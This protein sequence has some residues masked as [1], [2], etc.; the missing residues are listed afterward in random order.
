MR[1]AVTGGSGLAGFAVVEQF[2]TTVT[3][4]SASTVYR[5]RDRSPNSASSI[6]KTWAKFTAPALAPMPLCIWPPYHALS[7]THRKRS[8][9]PT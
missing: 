4:S 5:S 6:V 8:S 1:V 3:M 2:S 7:H 9:V